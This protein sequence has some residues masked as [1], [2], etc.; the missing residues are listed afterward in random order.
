MK[1]MNVL[2][3]GCLLAVTGI[4]AAGDL[5]DTEAVPMAYLSMP[6]GKHHSEDNRL[7]YGFGLAVA[8][9]GRDEGVNFMQT[10]RSR[11][12]DFSF[13]GDE[14]TALEVNGIN[15]LERKLVH[16]ADGTTSTATWVNY[17]I[18][19]PAVTIGAIVINET[20]DSSTVGRSSPEEN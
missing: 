13:T 1:P 10:G 9:Y 8:E 15:T 4:A 11:L 20:L 6:M 5:Q 19:V 16:H 12:L 17:S 3:G 7:Q 14:L 18:L 2:L